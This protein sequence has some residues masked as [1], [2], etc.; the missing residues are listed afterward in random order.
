LYKSKKIFVDKSLVVDSDSTNE[1]KDTLRLNLNQIWRFDQ[2]NSS[3]GFAPV[4]KV[5]DN[6]PYSVKYGKVHYDQRQTFLEQHQEIEITGKPIFNF[7]DFDGDKWQNQV[8]ALFSPTEEYV[9]EDHVFEAENLYSEKELD[10]AN[11]AG[12]SPPYIKVNGEYNFYIEQYENLISNANVSEA[13]MPNLYAFA[14][15]KRN[16]KS[17]DEEPSDYHQLIT[18]AGTLPSDIANPRSLSSNS[19]RATES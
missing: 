10:Q 18:L 5:T 13:L 8:G 15:E 4:L 11:E 12:F 19:K 6:I 3:L 17:M 14:S 16:P 7:L 9:N 2:E 1:V